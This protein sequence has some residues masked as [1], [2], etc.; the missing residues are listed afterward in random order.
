M[1]II[2]LEASDEE[3]AYSFQDKPDCNEIL[4]K[5]VDK[6]G[7]QVWQVT[8]LDATEPLEWLQCEGEYHASQA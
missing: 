6:K 2:H 1:Q 8:C 7:I 4:D 5:G 3:I